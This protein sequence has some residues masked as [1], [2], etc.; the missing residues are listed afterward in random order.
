[1]GTSVGTVIFKRIQVLIVISGMMLISNCGSSNLPASPTATFISSTE[2]PAATR[3]YLTDTPQATSTPEITTAILEESTSPDNKWTAAVTITTQGTSKHLQF[4]ATNNLDHTS[5]I[6]SSRDFQE[7]ENPLDGFVYPYVFQ[8]SKTGDHLYYSL[9]STGGDGC[10]TQSRPG[11]TDLYRY[12][13]NAEEIDFAVLVDYSSWIALSPK[14]EKLAYV[15]GWG[16]GVVIF[17]L[18]TRDRFV[19]QLPSIDNELS[20][21]TATRYIRWSPDGRSFVYAHLLGVCDY[22]IWYSY[23]IEVDSITR[24]QTILVDHDDRGYIPLEWNALDQIL[25]EDNDEQHWILNPNTK[26]ITPVQP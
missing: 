11:G 17:D 4:M 10:F 1:M 15:E 8:W 13:L 23:V 20:M 3:I 19:L 21:E 7:P 9:L 12:D 18:L 14:E 22:K 6:I 25:L 16:D 5:R 2:E 26:E 24:E